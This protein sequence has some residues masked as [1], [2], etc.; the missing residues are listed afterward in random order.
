VT[1]VQTCAL[2]ISAQIYLVDDLPRQLT[3]KIDRQALA[4][5]AERMAAPPGVPAADTS[6][7]DL[8]SKVA[9]AWG[10]VLG[11]T[12][13]PHDVNFFDLGGHSLAMFELQDALERATGIRPSV[14]GLFRH[15]TVSSQ[16]ALIAGGES[17]EVGDGG[18]NVSQVA[19]RRA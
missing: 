1:G 4:L 6:A 16:A 2:P 11:Q 19:A 14:V 15:T 10:E 17:A 7:G 3:G 18:S 9:A 12:T 5:V 8:I 13:V